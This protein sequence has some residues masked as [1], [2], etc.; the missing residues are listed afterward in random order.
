MI[1]GLTATY[2]LMYPFPK[3]PRV[4]DA[5]DIRIIGAKMDN[6]IFFFYFKE[7]A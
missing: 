5:S 7:W 2:N 3:A 1:S 4:T 6:F